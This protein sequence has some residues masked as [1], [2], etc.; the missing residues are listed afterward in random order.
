MYKVYL[1]PFFSFLFIW[2]GFLIFRELPIIYW[3]ELNE[4]TIFILVGSLFSIFFFYFSASFYYSQRIKVKNDEN[5]NIKSLCSIYKFLVFFA[6]ISLFLTLLNVIVQLKSYGLGFSLNSLTQLRYMK[7]EE[8]LFKGSFL[9]QLSLIFSTF[10]LIIYLFSMYYESFL[11]KRKKQL[12]LIILLSFMISTLS[13]GGRNPLFLSLLIILIAFLFKY[14]IKLKKKIFKFKYIIIFSSISIISIFIFGKI[15]LDREELRGRNIEEGINNILLGYDLKLN[16]IFV[17][18]L[19]IDILKEIS[20]TFFM[21]YFYA[22]HSLN[23][24]NNFIVDN[25]LNQE[26]YFGAISFYPIVKFLNK[27]GFNLPT[28]V[29]IKL[30]I[31]DTGT[32]KTLLGSL[33][34]DFGTFGTFIVLGIL[35]VVFVKAFS[36][37]YFKNSFLGFCI[38][39]IISMVFV[40]SPIYDTFSTGMI[41]LPFMISLIILYV[42]MK[43]NRI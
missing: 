1:Y 16:D 8:N 39:V 30:E 19:N 24:L 43:F 21:L 29:E 28:I 27:F 22:V 20:F 15:F 40:T 42:L 23:Q 10:P 26:L 37:Y 31:N 4:K 3:P 34:F 2:L 36:N 7:M 33:Y 41:F 25:Y 12:S 11:S 18:I 32:Y 35:S 14:K 5:V 17:A 13:G 38:A 6:L 9:Y